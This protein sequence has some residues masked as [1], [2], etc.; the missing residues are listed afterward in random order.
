MGRLAGGK[1]LRLRFLIFYFHVDRDSSLTIPMGAFLEDELEGFWERQGS[2]KNAMRGV[3][4]FLD[5]N[6]ELASSIMGGIF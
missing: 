6:Q 3:M 1:G 4:L 2:G 5:I